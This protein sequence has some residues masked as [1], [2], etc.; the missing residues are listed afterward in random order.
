MG[1]KLGGAC[2]QLQT[3]C[4]ILPVFADV[5]LFGDEA[6]V[7]FVDDHMGNIVFDECVAVFTV[8]ADPKFVRKSNITSAVG[9]RGE[10]QLIVLGIFKHLSVSLFIEPTEDGGSINRAEGRICHVVSFRVVRYN[11][12][13][14]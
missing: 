13:R 4:S 3:S 7:S 5:P 10:D 2:R 11:I 14:F 12:Y 9:K 8:G 6:M 1:H